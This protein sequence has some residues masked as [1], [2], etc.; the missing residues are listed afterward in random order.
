[1]DMIQTLV[2]E[3]AALEAD[4]IKAEADEQAAYE[5]FMKDS[6]ASVAAAMK[7]VNAKTGAKAKADADRTMASN[8]L[9]ATITD[10]LTLGEYNQELHKKC[11]FLVKNFDLR[12]SS[13]VQEMEALAQ[14]KA[15]FQGAKF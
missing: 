4:A 15:I 6:T 13:R 9:K 2:E 12:Q 8:D 5:S 7:S 14:A 3:S 1:M 10:L 11:D